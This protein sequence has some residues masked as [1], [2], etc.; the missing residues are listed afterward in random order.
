[1][2]MADCTLERLLRSKASRAASLLALLTGVVSAAPIA[3]VPATK[4]SSVRFWSLGEATRVS[5]EVSADFKYHSERLSDPDRIF[6][7]IQG[8]PAIAEKTMH[9]IPVGDPLLKQI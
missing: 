6:F 9:V 5:I 7:D 8:R 3:P 1:M 2:R 4:V